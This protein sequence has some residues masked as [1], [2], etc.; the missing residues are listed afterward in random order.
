MC[1]Y[2]CY[3]DGDIDDENGVEIV[4]GRNIFFILGWYN[5]KFKVNVCVL[6][7]VCLFYVGL[8]FNWINI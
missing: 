1:G 4:V 6:L 8:V 3:D 2:Y 5:L 7:C